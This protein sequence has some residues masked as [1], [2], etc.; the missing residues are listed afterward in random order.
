MMKK[1]LYISDLDGTLLNKNKEVPPKAVETLNALIDTK[2]VH[3][4]VATARTPATVEKILS[5]THIKEQIVVMNG[6]AIYDLKAHVYTEIA[7]IPVNSIDK[8]LSRCKEEIQEGFLY[9]INNNQ[10]GVYYQDLSRPERLAFFEE[11]QNLKY[12]KFIKGEPEQIE[13]IIYFVFIDTEEKIHEIA[14]KI[15]GVPQI[16]KVLY[17]DIY[18][19]E[20][21][22]LEVYSDKA[23]KANGVRRIKELGNYDEVIAFGDNYNDL[24]M[25]SVADRCYAVANAVD[26]VKH[27][28]DGVIGLAEEGSVVRFIENEIDM[29]K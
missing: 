26:E 20:G 23:T 1:R 24:P 19:N 21:W 12:K 3:F 13:D 11:R 17:K 29:S 28:A 16:A 6:A 5:D 8:I 9:T 14:K 25:F 18:S 15:E 7:A 2:R 22:I 10:L 4:S 27:K